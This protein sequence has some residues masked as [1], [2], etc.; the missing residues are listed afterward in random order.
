MTSPAA[1]P[2]KRRLIRWRRLAPRL[3]EP[4]PAVAGNRVTSMERGESFY[5]T[6]LSAIAQARATVDVEMY[7]WDADE[8][9]LRF[10]EALRDAAARGLRVRVLI[11]ASGASEIAARLEAVAGAGG[12]VRI[13]NPFR[14]RFLQRYFHRTH[15]KLVVCDG[16]RAFTGGAGFSQHWTSGKRREEPWHDR[17]FEMHGPA[18]SQIVTLFETDF[19][20]WA[21]RREATGSPVPAATTDLAP[22][23]TAQLR[24]LRGWP[25]ARD[26]RVALIAAVRAAKVRVWLG[27]PYFIP[28]PSLLRELTSALRRGVD[29]QL[30][31][32]SGNYAHPLLWHASRRHY[33][34]FIRRGARI[35]EYAQGFYHVKIAVVDGSAAIFGSSNLDYWSWDRNAEIDVVA[36][37]EATV[38]L[39]AACFEQ[40]RSR[41]REVTYA[42]VSVRSW[43]ARLRDRL[44]GWIESWL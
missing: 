32:P 28:P 12:D 13:F 33:K 17:I 42:D 41:S 23:G 9:G 24:V 21:P 3:R 22:A 43:L 25:N 2:A 11:D 7:L 8:V 19:H 5:A 30:V 35:H 16:W 4:F 29:V 34:W 38:G 31:L 39:V 10:V 1:G 37:D 6:M 40:D 14:M 26:F 36:T 44:V 20:R 18:V 15:K 27:T